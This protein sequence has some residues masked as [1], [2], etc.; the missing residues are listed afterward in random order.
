MQTLP[1][2]IKKVSRLNM[3]TVI[4]EKVGKTRLAFA[5]IRQDKARKILQNRD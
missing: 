3:A 1:F 5:V 2:F 4:G